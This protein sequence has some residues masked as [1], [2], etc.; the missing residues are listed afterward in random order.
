MNGPV[1]AVVCVPTYRRPAMLAQTLASLARQRTARSFATVVIDNDASGRQGL[2]VALAC[3]AAGRLQGLARLQ[4][5]Q[6]NCH[7]INA[8][9]EAAAAAY[10]EARFLLMIDDDEVAAPDWLE[11]LVATAEE[12]GV[13]IV[14][15]PVHSRFEPQPSPA[16]AAHPVF[17]P[18]FDRS[19]PVPM[20]YGSGNFLVR[21]GSLRRLPDPRFNLDFNTLGG[22]DTDFFTRCRRAGFRFWWNEA[23][24][25]EETVPVSRQTIGWI[26]R[27]GLRIGAINYRIDRRHAPTGSS[28][29]RVHGKN[30]ALVPVSLWRAVRSLARSRSA[31]IAAHPLAVAAGRL[32]ASVGIE[33][34]QYRASSAP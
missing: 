4:P 6:G 33:A 29:L 19:G 10:P 28:V 7:A 12:T 15:G 34:H 31:L 13:D 2:E 26:L 30:A 23:A 11:Q 16:V 9:F 24:R 17:H 32:L 25:I 14:G 5:E 18:A 22:G 21:T 27:R 3:F 8:G 1:E 20:I